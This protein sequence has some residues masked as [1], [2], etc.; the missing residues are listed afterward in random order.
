MSFVNRV[1]GASFDLFRYRRSGCRENTRWIARSVFARDA[2]YRR[3][4][5][6]FCERQSAAARRA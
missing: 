6:L 2:R 4:L 5:G 3:E 1:T